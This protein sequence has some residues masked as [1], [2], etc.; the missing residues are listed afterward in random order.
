LR[1]LPQA[2][3]YLSRIQATQ[4]VDGVVRPALQSGPCIV[5]AHSLGTVITYKIMR[6]LRQ[7]APLYLTLGSPLAIRAVQGKI[8]T[9]FGR[10]PAVER[11]LN[12]FDKDDFVTIGRPLDSSTFG[13]GVEN[14]DVDN[15]DDDPHSSHK[16]LSQP[17]VARQLVA[18]IRAA[19]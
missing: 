7:V 5:V 4:A 9:P 1:F 3:T 16:Y 17:D 13:A 14:T 2:F 15:A 6:E 18:A 11:W 8:G 19:G 10:R 12:V